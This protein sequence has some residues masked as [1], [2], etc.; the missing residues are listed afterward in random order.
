MLCFFG[1]IKWK[2]VN[3]QKVKLL[4]IILLTKLDNVKWKQNTP[5]CLF[6]L[7][8]PGSYLKCFPQLPLPGFTLSHKY[9]THASK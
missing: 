1:E 2:K 8:S 3:K 4:Y 7:S 5:V 6:E 9:F